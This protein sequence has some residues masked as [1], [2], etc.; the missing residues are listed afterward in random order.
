MEEREADDEHDMAHHSSNHLHNHHIQ[1]QRNETLVE[2]SLGDHSIAEQNHQEE[3]DKGCVPRSDDDGLQSDGDQGVVP[4]IVV[5]ESDGD[6]LAV[7]SIVLGESDVDRLVVPQSI[8]NVDRLRHGIAAAEQ[9]NQNQN[10]FSSSSFSSSLE[11]IQRSKE[12]QQ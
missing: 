6:Q 8:A 1:S 11:E 2:Q 4:N 3:D 12:Q 5:G 7:P 9:V 10:L